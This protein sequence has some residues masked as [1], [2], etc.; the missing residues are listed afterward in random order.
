MAK[1]PA[2]AF[3]A[4]EHGPRNCIG[5][6]LAIVKGKVVLSMIARR[7]EFEKIGMTGKDDEEEVY[8]NIAVYKR[9]L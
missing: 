1:R 3:R 8:N 9:P 4:F 7:F 6:D 2:G 5:Q